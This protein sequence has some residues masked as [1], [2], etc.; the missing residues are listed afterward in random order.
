M[1]PLIDYFLTDEQKEI[2]HLVRSIAEKEM[3][4]VVEQYDRSG[5]FP[6]PIVKILA[7]ND[8]FRV[9]I[10][11]SYGGIS[12]KTPSFNTVVVMEEL[13]RVCAGIALSFGGTV[14]GAL[15][16]IVAGNREQK[17][18][19]LPEIAAG[20]K[21]AS[22]AISEHQAGSDMNAMTCTASREGAEYVINGSKKWITNAGEAEIY[23]VFCLTGPDKGIKGM[24]CILVEKN[25]EGLEFG[26]IE[27]KLGVRAS[28]TREVFFDGCRVPVENRLGHEGSGLKTMAKVLAL[29]R[30]SVAAQALGIAQGSMDL[31]AGYARGRRQ[32]GKA[33]SEFQGV[34][35][36]L[37][38][39]AM[40][41]EAA[42]AITYASARYLDSHGDT[43]TM[44]PSA[45]AKC[46]ASDAAMKIA[47]DAL[48]VYGAYGYVRDYPI[49]KYLRDA[50]ITQIYEGTNQVLRDLIGKSIARNTTG[51]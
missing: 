27:D 13:S 35:F 46:V 39:M 31:A 34:R 38:D 44:I 18:R 47:T 9:F 12:N 36:L 22:I 42:R 43:L 25:A 23:T 28:V 7:R 26:R 17:A 33:I 21:L 37:A 14:A 3:R 1:N 24:S 19:F 51:S 48:Q 11:E 2:Q 29:S 6:W 4:P 49:E 15:P 32:F 20:R 10:D 8:I 5:Q 45:M 50:K 40:Q 41:L 30:P 16:I